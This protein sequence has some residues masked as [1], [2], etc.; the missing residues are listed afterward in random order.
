M[1]HSNHL[2]FY[3]RLYG[4]GYNYGKGPFLIV[5]EEIRWCCYY[6]DY[7]LRLAASHMELAGAPWHSVRS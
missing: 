3:L 7:Y 1:T 6:M 2:R 4:V 5:R